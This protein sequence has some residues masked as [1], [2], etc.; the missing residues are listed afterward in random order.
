MTLRPRFDPYRAA[1]VPSVIPLAKAAEPEM[2]PVVYTLLGVPYAVVPDRRYGFLFKAARRKPAPGQMSFFDAPKPKA[3]KAPGTGGR[4]KMQEGAT[5]MKNGQQ[6]VLKN[7]RWRN[8]EPKGKATPKPGLSIL[9]DDTGTTLKP[10]ARK[11]K[12]WQTSPPAKAPAAVGGAAMGATSLRP[13]AKVT[14]PKPLT[15][16]DEDIFEDDAP[17]T[18]VAAE[19]VADD[20]PT[21]LRPKIRSRAERQKDIDDLKGTMQDAARSAIRGAAEVADFYENTVATVADGMG[22][23]DNIGELGGNRAMA[24][25]MLAERDPLQA[26]PTTLRPKRR[27]RAERQKDIDEIKQNL[28]DAGVSTLEAAQAHEEMLTSALGALADTYDI[29][30]GDDAGLGGTNAPQLEPTLGDM[31]AE[32]K[33]GAGDG[34]VIEF[35]DQAKELVKNFPAK[36]KAEKAFKNQLNAAIKA[37]TKDSSEGSIKSATQ[38]LDKAHDKWNAVK[39]ER[40]GDPALEADSNAAYDAIDA[41]RAWLRGPH[42]EQSSQIRN[43]KRAHSVSRI[44]SEIAQGKRARTGNNS[45]WRELKQHGMA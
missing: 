1:M 15:L 19:V 9:S 44:D 18:P 16:G 21:T 34:P 45:E 5:R 29:D 7:S 25:A 27:T 3:P 11:G 6:Q 35:A 12:E 4:K 30:L 23:G 33:A 20:E 10:K 8:V 38:A 28:Y 39:A 32:Q 24:E 36:T 13:K 42:S 2:P 40:W 22:V 14:L 43:A 31:L 26:E 17:A 41:L 37:A